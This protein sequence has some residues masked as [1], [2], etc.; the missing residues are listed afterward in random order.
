MNALLDSDRPM[1]RARRNRLP[2]GAIS[3]AASIAPGAIARDL[4]LNLWCHRVNARQ[5]LDRLADRGRA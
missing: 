3:G 2:G 1:C 5:S 4:A